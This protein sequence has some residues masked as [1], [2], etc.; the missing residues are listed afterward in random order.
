MRAQFLNGPS[1]LQSGRRWLYARKHTLVST[2]GR[3]PIRRCLPRET[4][5]VPELATVGARPLRARYL[6]ERARKRAVSGGEE[7]RRASGVLADIEAVPLVSTFTRPSN[8]QK[9]ALE[10]HPVLIRRVARR[11]AAEFLVALHGT[12]VGDLHDDRLAERAGVAW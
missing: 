12:H 3:R 7:L 2:A 11:L 6:S 4:R 5:A 8:E 9:Y 1:V 10:R